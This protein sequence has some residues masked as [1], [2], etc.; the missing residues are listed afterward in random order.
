MFSASKLE[1]MKVVEIFRESCAEEVCPQG[2][3]I[4]GF[5]MKRRKVEEIPELIR[6][7][8]DGIF[9]KGFWFDDSQFNEV[10]EL[11]GLPAVRF[12]GREKVGL[13]MAD[14]GEGS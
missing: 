4:F 7:G 12:L 9:R 14:E 13:L 8:I 3:D 11:F 5:M 2:V 10:R 6:R 1:I